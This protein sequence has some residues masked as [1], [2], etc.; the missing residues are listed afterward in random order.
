M[1]LISFDGFQ[2]YGSPA[3]TSGKYAVFDGALG[4]GRRASSGAAELSASGAITLLFSAASTLSR[5]FA[6]KQPTLFATTILEFS[7]SLGEQLSLRTTA[8]G[9]LYVSR[10]GST[11][12]SSASDPTYRLKAGQWRYIE[13]SATIS[14]SA[15]TWALQVAGI[16]DSLVQ[17]SG[18]NTAAQGGT[19]ADRVTFR[20]SAAGASAFADTYLRNDLTFNGDCRVDRLLPSA[21][22]F[23]ADY[24][25]YGAATLALA[26]DDTSPN[27]DTDYIFSN[28]VGEIGSVHMADLAFTPETVFGVN[29]VYYAK[30]SEAGTRAL[31]IGIRSGGT[32]DFGSPDGLTLAYARYEDFLADN[33]ITSLPFTISDIASLELAVKTET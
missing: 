11:I 16:P 10:N 26:L 15:G 23:H 7:T 32:D 8:T 2:T 13:F 17:G 25:V 22:G 29:A 14:T 18:V 9:Q 27:G 28:T 20:Q 1:A 3:D 33:P 12:W 21:D 30:L 31:S 4:A 19:T 24:G 5:G 6:Y